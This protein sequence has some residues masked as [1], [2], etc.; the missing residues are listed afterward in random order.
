MMVISI[1]LSIVLVGL[2]ITFFV[3]SGPSGG[4]AAW[5]IIVVALA[6]LAVL[7]VF[8][9]RYLQ[10]RKIKNLSEGY[11]EAYD[12]IMQ[13]IGMTSLKLVDKREVGRDLLDMFSEATQAG[14]S[15]EDLIGQ[16]KDIE[17]FAKAILKAHGLKNNFASYIMLGFQYFIIYLF[18]IQ[19]YNYFRDQS[20]YES[21]FKAQVDY[22]TILFFALAALVIIPLVYYY[23]KRAMIKQSGMGVFLVPFLL[24]PLG[25]SALFIGS[26]ELI[27]AKL[28]HI[29]WI[30]Q[31]Y[32][33]AMSVV[34][35]VFI[36]VL[37]CLVFVGI[38]YIRRKINKISY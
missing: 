12:K 25:I 23:L 18:V 20:V 31:F 33:G 6:V 9:S 11:K 1:V 34:P 22:T 8:I 26:M 32:N 5:L 13:Y 35:N 7:A 38:I 30:N 4:S 24:V 29:H 37:L 17:N 15:L 27:K 16:E 2:A 36:L 28:L 14:K 3:K 10:E 21:Y 19:G